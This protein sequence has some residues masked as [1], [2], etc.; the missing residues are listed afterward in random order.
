MD[1]AASHSWAGD[2]R[3]DA[4]ENIDTTRFPSSMAMAR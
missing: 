4:L 1:L 3:V 2:R